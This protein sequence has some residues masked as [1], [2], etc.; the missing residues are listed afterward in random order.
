[1]EWLFSQQRSERVRHRRSDVVEG[2]LRLMLEQDTFG[3][4]IG[5]PGSEGVVLR[6]LT[7][8]ADQEL[9]EQLCERLL[10]APGVVPAHVRPD[11]RSRLG[12][13]LLEPVVFRRG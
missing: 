4:V 11:E 8:G 1:M 12:V 5:E 13:P 10:D 6:F 2:A 7:C 9:V 3:E